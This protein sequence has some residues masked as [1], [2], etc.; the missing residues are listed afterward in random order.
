MSLE[1]LT[2]THSIK[3][4]RKSITQDASGGN[5]NTWEVIHERVSVGIQ[6]A[7]AKEKILFAQRQILYD[8][9]I[10]SA[11]DLAV[12]KNDRVTDL[13]TLRQ[14]TVVGYADQAGQDR[15]FCINAREIE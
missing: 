6:P 4:E 12:N 7:S 15:V 13:K 14:Y 1:S 5:V 11:R 9:K 3:I 2:Q 10:Y 8:N